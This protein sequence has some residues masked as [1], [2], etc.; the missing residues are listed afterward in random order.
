M[1]L[2]KLFYSNDE[3]EC[4]KSMICLTGF[5][6][7]YSNLN[8]LNETIEIILNNI[9]QMNFIFHQIQLFIHLFFFFMIK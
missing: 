2:R 7:L 9:V 3:N 4:W 1:Y 8:C 6:Y 5:D